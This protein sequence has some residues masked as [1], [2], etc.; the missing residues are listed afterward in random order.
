MRLIFSSFFHR[1]PKCAMPI[2]FFNFCF[3]FS[4]SVSI[5]ISVSFLS[6]VYAYILLPH[7]SKSW[8]WIRFH[9]SFHIIIVCLLLNLISSSSSPFHFFPLF[10]FSFT[11]CV[12]E[13]EIAHSVCGFFLSFLFVYFFC[14]S[15]R[16]LPNSLPR[17]QNFMYTQGIYTRALAHPLLYNYSF[18]S[19][20]CGVFI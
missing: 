14:R 9:K 16:T 3:S 18:L 19:L 12:C 20:C 8:F 17:L 13:R 5:S 11:A 15:A 2:T 6:L 7:L 10:S 4:L 1:L